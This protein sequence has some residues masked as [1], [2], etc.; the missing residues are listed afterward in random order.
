MALQDP[1]GVASDAQDGLDT[2]VA[3]ITYNG[4]P[5]AAVNTG[6]VT[7]AGTPYIITY[8]AQDKC[9]NSAT[10]VTRTVAVISPC[11]SPEV[12]CSSGEGE[13]LRLGGPERCAHPSRPVY[14]R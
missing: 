8:A 7:P 2:L 3:A 5:A 1:G 9:C 12:L 11:I 13:S 6:L 10:P 4:N 14:L